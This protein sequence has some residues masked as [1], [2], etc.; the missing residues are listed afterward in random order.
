MP[1]CV[2]EKMFPKNVQKQG[3]ELLFFKAVNRKPTI[4]ICAVFPGKMCS[5]W[6]VLYQELDYFTAIIRNMFPN[7]C[8]VVCAFICISAF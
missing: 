8:V 2:G 7:R 4:F 5:F 1:L 6:G 3:G